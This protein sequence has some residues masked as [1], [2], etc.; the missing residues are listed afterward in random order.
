[1]LLDDCIYEWRII[2]SF[3]LLTSFLK[4]GRREKLIECNCTDLYSWVAGGVYIYEEG[5]VGLGTG[6]GK[7]RGVGGRCKMDL[8]WL[9]HGWGGW[10][11]GWKRIYGG[12]FI[13]NY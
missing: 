4:K 3:I 10:L 5:M 13:T 12:D 1:M 6:R 2:L 7:P 11:R 8:G 9:V